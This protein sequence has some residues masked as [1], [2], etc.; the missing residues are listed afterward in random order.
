MHGG[1]AAP[2][3]R[4]QMAPP[5]QPSAT[6]A[7]Y[8]KRPAAPAPVV[9]GGHAGLDPHGRRALQPRPSEEDHLEIPAFLRRQANH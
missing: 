1:P 8:G 7:E 4:P 3:P 2:T 5:G 6:H 9:P